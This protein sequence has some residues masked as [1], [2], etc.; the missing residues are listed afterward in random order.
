MESNFA[1]SY[2]LPGVLAIIMVGMGLSLTKH[3]FKNILVHP[4]SLLLGL[5]SQM[6][7][8]PAI[9]F[10][11]STIST[12]SNELK[13]G[14]IIIS[15][16]PGGATSNLIT[17]LLKGR[18]ALSISLTTVNSLLT[19]V[20]VPI[21]VIFGL[22]S[23]MGETT[24]LQMPVVNTIL[25]ILLITLVPTAVGI[26]IRAKRPGLSKS[27]EKPLRYIMPLM[28]GTVFL[29]AILGGRGA[30]PQGTLNLYLRITP[31]VLMLNLAGMLTGFL[32]AR[33]FRLGRRN[34]VTLSIEVGIQNSALAITIASSQMFLN[35]YMMA[36][37]AVV[38]GLFTF[39]NAVIFGYL[40][41]KMSRR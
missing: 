9:A 13:V 30:D 2:L 8:L 33:I 34:E 14:I 23:F 3:D 26:F 28:L 21:I 20:T 38:Y 25:K 29:V 16:C 24:A 19:L 4:K 6:I 36:A 12:L 22:K 31:W 15:A 11:I 41:K 1:S 37:P 17:H 5:A 35:N 7:I 10:G 18:V 39:F 40:V 32:V 27:L